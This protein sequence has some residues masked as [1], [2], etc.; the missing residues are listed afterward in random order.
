MS[1]LAESVLLSRSGL[2]R[3]ADRLAKNGLIT[4]EECPTDQRGL[5]AAITDEGR[6]LFAEAGRARPPL[7]G[8]RPRFLVRLSE[9]EQRLLGEVWERLAANSPAPPATGAR[10]GAP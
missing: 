1:D 3:L 4:R 10:G 8:V 9:D 2:T 7:A 6:R 5:F